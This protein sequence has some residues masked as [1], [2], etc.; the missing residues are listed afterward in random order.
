MKTIKLKF[1]VDLRTFSQDSL[2][3]KYGPSFHRF[4]PNNQKDKLEKK[5]TSLNGKIS[6]WFERRGILDDQFIKYDSKNKLEN[7]DTILKQGILDGGPL[8]GQI[9]VNDVSIELFQVLKDNKI[10]D[11]HYIVFGKKIV[12]EIIEHSTILVNIFRELYR[13]YWIGNDQNW[14]SRY[15]SLGSFC[16]WN[17]SLKYSIDN[18][19]TWNDFIPDEER[20]ELHLDSLISF[21]FSDFISNKDWIEIK[22]LFKKS[23]KPSI[24]SIYITRAH[25]TCDRG[26]LKKAFIESVTA[27]EMALEYKLNGNKQLTNPILESVQSFTAL[28]IKS[29]FS[30]F[31]LECGKVKSIEIENSLEA[32]KIRNKIVHEG[33]TP[34]K[35]EKSKLYSLL[36]SISLM[37]NEPVSKFPSSNRGNAIQSVKSWEKERKK[38]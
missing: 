25:E 7:E 28:P 20:H 38:N 33:Y 31:A 8:F 35:S 2:D 16:K 21:D 3:Q 30:I 34:K 5:L 12:K 18:G 10:G 36:A 17:L 6:L 27:L 29:Q 22:S 24:A 37:I 15:Q 1:I 11:T 13:Q 19:R 32:I 26:D 4:L 9:F 23:F 14:D